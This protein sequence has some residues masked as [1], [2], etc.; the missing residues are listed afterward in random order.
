MTTTQTSNRSLERLKKIAVRAQK[1]KMLYING[2]LAS[3][4]SVLA[5][6][7]AWPTPFAVGPE[8]DWTPPLTRIWL[9]HWKAIVLTVAASINWA[10]FFSQW[11]LTRVALPLIL[12]IEALESMLPVKGE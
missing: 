10:V 7:Y 6:V 1:W 4:L 2:V 8:A 3:L 9:G 5:I 11:T 12:R